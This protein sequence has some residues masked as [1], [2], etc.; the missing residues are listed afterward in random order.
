MGR[1]VGRVMVGEGW[2]GG[3]LFGTLVALGVE[4]ILTVLVGA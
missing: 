4:M 2:G 1:R 3:G